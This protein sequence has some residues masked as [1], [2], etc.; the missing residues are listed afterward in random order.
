M[1]RISC[2]VAGVFLAIATIARA[3]SY[4]PAMADLKI[5]EADGERDL[6]G[7]VWYPTE[8]AGPLT[9]DFESEVWVGTQI[10]RD[11]KPS[12]GPF[13]LVV[14]SHGMYGNAYNQAWLASAL[15]RKGYVVAAINHPGT[16]TWS[17]DPDL[18]RQLWE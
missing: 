6:S 12:E 17:R 15:A 7:F 16:S 9:Y 1:A 13:P 10:V 5:S 2:V 3:Q 18:T 11:A 4:E 14:L 8:A